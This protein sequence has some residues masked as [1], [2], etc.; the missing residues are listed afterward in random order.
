MIEKSYEEIAKEMF[1][2]PS[3]EVKSMSQPAT[4]A[5]SNLKNFYF[6]K[7]DSLKDP[8]AYLRDLVMTSE[9]V[10]IPQKFQFLSFLQLR[11]YRIL[12]FQDLGN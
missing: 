10:P 2:C 9:L 1:D 8:Y 4:T 5:G 7:F 12:P 11:A 6:K 3:P